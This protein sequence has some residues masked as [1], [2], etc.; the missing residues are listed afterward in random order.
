MAAGTWSSPSRRRGKGSFIFRV[1][2]GKDIWRLI[3]LPAD[4][5]LDDLASWILRSMKFDNDHLYEFRYRD[6]LGATAQHRPPGDGRGSLDGRGRDRRRCRCEPGQTME[7]L[8]DFGDD[9]RF[10]VKLERIEPPGAKIK[11]PAILEKH[12]KSPEQYP[13]SD[14]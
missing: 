8:F 12:G 9:W 4:D 10:D 13:D 3:A 7:F 5:T 11:A 1:A 2:L 6:R 14:W